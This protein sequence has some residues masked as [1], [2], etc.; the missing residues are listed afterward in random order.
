MVIKRMSYFNAKLSA[1]PVNSLHDLSGEGVVKVIRQFLLADAA[2]PLALLRTVSSA[3]LINR[4]THFGREPIRIAGS[5]S[6]H[7]SRNRAES[8]LDMRPG[9]TENTHL[10]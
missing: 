7:F 3:S 5:A 2:H 6:P 10:A 8:V 9:V 1:L 4:V